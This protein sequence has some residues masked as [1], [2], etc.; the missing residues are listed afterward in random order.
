LQKKTRER[1][2]LKPSPQK[3]APVT[4]GSNE[5]QFHGKGCNRTAAGNNEF[6]EY[7]MNRRLTAGRY[8]PNAN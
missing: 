3:N 7:D 1:P 5:E 4:E 8:E 6:D 2:F